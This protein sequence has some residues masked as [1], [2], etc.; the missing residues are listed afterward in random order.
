RIRASRLMKS[1]CNA[2][3]P[4]SRFRSVLVVA[5]AVL[6][7]MLCSPV[8]PRW[9]P[10]R[11]RLQLRV[12]PRRSGGNDVPLLRRQ[13]RTFRRTALLSR[14]AREQ[15][16]ADGSGEPSY[17]TNFCAEVILETLLFAGKKT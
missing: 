12:P 2:R 13:G 11:L 10:S 4:N 5:M 9:T 6:C 1:I 7:E 17:R 3:M 15:G 14:P 8:F 16:K